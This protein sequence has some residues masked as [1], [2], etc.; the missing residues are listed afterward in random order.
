MPLNWYGEID[1]RS[2]ID[3]NIINNWVARYR[4]LAQHHLTEFI[5]NS[6]Q[7]MIQLSKTTSQS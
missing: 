5:L 1:I 6:L 3:S 4:Q 2:S 7:N